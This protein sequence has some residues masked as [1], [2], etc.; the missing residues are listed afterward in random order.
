M[1]QEPATAKDARFY[2]YVGSEW[3]GP[4]QVEQV[5]FFLRQ[6]QV[7]ADTYAYEPDLQRHY[8]VGELLAESDREH[9]GVRPAPGAASATRASSRLN[10]VDLEEDEL[11]PAQPTATF[12]GLPEAVR[13]FYNRYL[14]L[15][16]N[17]AVDW[18]ISRNDLL[19]SYE[20]LH[21]GLVAV[22]SDAVQAR[23][24]VGEIERIA[25]YIANRHQDARLWDLLAGLR[26]VNPASDPETAVANALAVLE[27]LFQKADQQQA[28]LSTLV[29]SIDVGSGQP[30]TESQGGTTKRVIAA[31]QDEVALTHQD[32]EAIQRA[33]QQLQETHS[34]ELEQ[35]REL[36]AQMESARD[37][38]A[39]TAA[40]SEAE[41]RSLAAEIHDLARGLVESGHSELA[42]EV[43]QLESELKE[44][45]ATTIAP[46]A[47][48]VL[49]RMVARLRSLVAT[50][51]TVAE[52]AEIAALRDE[53]AR[54]RVELVQARAEAQRNA[55][56]RDRAQRQLAEQRAAAERAQEAAK[57][58]EQRLRSTVTALEVT[59]D[60]HQEVMR[61]LQ[62]QHKGAQARVESMEGELERVRNELNQA[63]SDLESRTEDLQDEM[64]RAVEL[65]AML[66]ARRT[67][68]NAD[69]KSAEQELAKARQ[70][71]DAEVAEALAI[72]VNH[73]R[74][75]VEATQRRLAEQAAQTAKLEEELAQSRREAGELRKR[76]DS[77]SGELDQARQ[78]LALAQRRF[79]ELQR[80][81][82]Q[83]ESER[84]SLQAEL[85]TR[86]GTDTVRPASESVA[87]ESS[88]R[89]P[90]PGS[91]ALT[92][93]HSHESS[94][95]DPAQPVS[96]RLNR[97][98][99]SLE[100]RLQ[101]AQRR[102]ASLDA[103]LG[104]ERRRVQELA[105]KES[106]F[107]GR[108]DELTSDRD[109]L[110]SEL[111]R[112]HSEHFA[113]HSRHAAAIAVATQAT[114]DAER[115]YKTAM[116]RVVELENRLSEISDAPPGMEALEPRD[117]DPGTT[118]LRRELEEARSQHASAVG[119]LAAAREE[120]RSLQRSVV[121]ERLAALE[122]EHAGAVA[123]R[124]ALQAELLAATSERDRMGRELAR[125]RNEQESAAVEHRTA[126]KSARDRLVEAQ[127][128]V[129]AL[130][131]AMEQARSQA[132]PG[133]E[134]AEQ[135]LAVALAEQ[136]RL[137]GECRRL[138]AELERA[139]RDLDGRRDSG[140]GDLGDAARQLA[141]EQEK[142]AALSRSLDEV[143]QAASTARTRAAELEARAAAQ[144]A[145]RDRMQIEL[146]RLRSTVA[147][148]ASP[149]ADA[150]LQEVLADRDHLLGE[151]ERVN[152]ELTD[153][154][155]HHAK[156]EREAAQL[157]SLGQEQARLHGLEAR[158]AALQADASAAQ[159]ATE[160]ARGRLAEIELERDQLKAEVERLRSGGVDRQELVELRERLARAKR[161]IRVLRRQRDRLREHL[162]D[163]T[164]ARADL[165]SQIEQLRSTQRRVAAALGVQTPADEQPGSGPRQALEAAGSG[166]PGT[167]RAV[168]GDDAREVAPGNKSSSAH[169]AVVVTSAL[170]KGR[171]PAAHRPQMIVP[172]I[173]TAAVRRTSTQAA[174]A[175]ER[176]S[177]RVS[178]PARR[179]LPWALAGSG[180][181]ALALLSP[182][183]PQASGR[184]D[185]P[186]TVLST[187]VRGHLAG[188][189]PALRQPFAAGEQVVRI[190]DPTP[191]TALLASLQAQL[192]AERGKEALVLRLAASASAAGIAL[193][194]ST[195]DP[196]LIRCRQHQEE[197]LR[198]I[199]EEQT[200][201]DAMRSA[202][203]LSPGP[204]MLWSLRRGES[205][206]PGAPVAELVP[207]L[208]DEI[209]IAQDLPE[210][211]KVDVL[212]PDGQRFRGTV[213]RPADQ[214]YTSGRPQAVVR[215]P[216]PQ[217][218]GRRADLVRLGADPGPL[219]ELRAWWTR[220]TRP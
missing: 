1:A 153:L 76:S 56:E 42:E 93:A 182:P 72:K 99:E 22:R 92:R 163:S 7:S 25:D 73:L 43:T 32:L 113:E 58:R 38:M 44:A 126:L 209:A 41:L 109:H 27:H 130:E 213:A 112:L 37:D 53:L 210:G 91:P 134:E 141:A 67:E 220:L 21:A 149:A 128:K 183:L 85:V 139:R 90:R 70:G 45:D 203:L 68:L 34:R 184:A 119:D 208:A 190:E 156:I 104:E 84:E 10:I 66:E 152:K 186:L 157:E 137:D 64:R 100:A 207:L 95:L 33:Y 215:L 9:S 82:G 178:R 28:S 171:R 57:A 205:F 196:E 96:M 87:H 217:P 164:R 78:G 191:D 200:R 81:Y 188:S 192:D 216:Q 197:L 60:L 121:A 46:L 219:T 3:S 69:L 150:R 154:R 103:Q 166:T 204:L 98:V 111:D 79:G 193:L 107:A 198:R 135:R 88:D 133:A 102:V 29:P 201:L 54:T 170:M 108:I 51:G 17:R 35:A 106:S 6:G 155:R 39:A 212:L 80:A 20:G 161:R 74:T 83:L 175:A 214:A 23:N 2:L 11:L 158:I 47:E 15:V 24:R 132:G 49:I 174:A 160:A 180:L 55:E 16:E 19:N 110:R 181:F 86:K 59:K 52:P 94:R 75:L 26:E 194:G 30:A 97:V 144:A 50:P 145:E 206:L 77:L 127:E 123:A 62:S 40:Q 31:V 143:Q 176:S 122:K 195:E 131:L 105:Q 140:L 63:R 202:R 168:L 172:P 151:L 199:G 61:D 114:I 179:W 138:T 142:V 148:T 65:R 162:A 124:S 36:L 117:G 5:R 101:E 89:E 167:R 169:T 13:A 218:I 159:A 136:E 147:R 165:E 118:A 129:K 116:E 48:G 185:A 115:R 187:P 173:P 177:A 146:E 71:A 18:N 189:L 125:L 14:D 12:E 8:T 211:E 4:F 120:A